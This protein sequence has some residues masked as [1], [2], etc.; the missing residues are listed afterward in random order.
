MLSEIQH[1][2][3]LVTWGKN[4]QGIFRVSLHIFHYRHNNQ[5][6]YSLDHTKTTIKRMERLDQ[7][8]LLHGA[9]GFMAVELK[10]AEEFYKPHCKYAAA[11]LQT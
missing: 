2:V 8:K 5:Q 9:V 6:I 1:K 3:S 10:G 11:F 4:F 7:G